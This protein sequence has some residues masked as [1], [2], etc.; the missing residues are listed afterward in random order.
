MVAMGRELDED[1]TATTI[2][3]QQGKNSKRPAVGWKLDKEDRE[4]I[5]LS[6]TELATMWMQLSGIGARR[7]HYR[8][9]VRRR[10]PTAV[11]TALVREGDVDPTM[12][13]WGMETK[14]VKSSGK[15]V[16]LAC[17][18]WRGGRDR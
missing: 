18:E 6:Y 7:R 5:G 16:D 4:K 10:A 9:G 15:V 17:P 3:T 12:E 14:E 1:G 11:A 13:R 8:A 2:G